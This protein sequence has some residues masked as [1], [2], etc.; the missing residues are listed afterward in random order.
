[1]IVFMAQ[2]SP[3]PGPVAVHEVAVTAAWL[4]SPLA[5]GI[6]ASVIYEDKGYAAMGLVWG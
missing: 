3:L 1:M 6:T 4:A 2:R 5:T